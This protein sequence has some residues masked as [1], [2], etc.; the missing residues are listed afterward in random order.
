[1]TLTND[2]VEISTSKTEGFH[3]PLELGP[4]SIRRKHFDLRALKRF[5][6]IA[7]KVERGYGSGGTGRG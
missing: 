7:K 2:I 5:I 6:S 1:M 4:E 3:F